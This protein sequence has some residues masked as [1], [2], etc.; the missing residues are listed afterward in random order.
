[1]LRIGST[2]MVLMVILVLALCGGSVH[3][4]GNGKLAFTNSSLY[5]DA[6]YMNATLDI[7]NTSKFTLNMNAL[8]DMAKLTMVVDV[9]IRTAENAPYTSFM[10]KSMNFCNFLDNPM[11]DPIVYMPYQAIQQ[12]KK[13]HL[14]TKCPIKKVS[15]VISG[16]PTGLCKIFEWHFRASTTCENLALTLMFCRQCCKKYVST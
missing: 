12:S 1:M 6:V 16:T 10:K 2:K 8:A 11:S 5:F 7:I 15:H 9:N 13:N 4:A 3:C 14:F